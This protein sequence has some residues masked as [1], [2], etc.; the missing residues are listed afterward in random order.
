MQQLH[1]W[2]VVEAQML[3]SP[4]EKLFQRN[5]SKIS[6]RKFI[7]QFFIHILTDYFPSAIF[8]S[9]TWSENFRKTILFFLSF[10]ILSSL[11]LLMS[12]FGSKCDMNYFDISTFSLQQSTIWDML[13]WP[14]FLHVICDNFSL[15]VRLSCLVFSQFVIY[16]NGFVFSYCLMA[17]CWRRGSEKGQKNVTTSSEISCRHKHFDI[18]SH[19]TRLWKPFRL[20]LNPFY[21]IFSNISFSISWKCANIDKI[22]VLSFF[23]LK[24][25]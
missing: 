6:W 23:C 4:F 25:K 20:K 15:F 11:P 21:W 3:C 19:A 12:W 18:K 24:E 2:L 13:W 17:C 1:P 5:S 22:F 14:I 9:K 8:L 16:E 7:V 10:F